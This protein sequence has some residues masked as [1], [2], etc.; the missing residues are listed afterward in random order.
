MV[1]TLAPRAGAQR[2]VVFV[3]LAVAFGF[4]LWR[5]VTTTKSRTPAPRASTSADRLGR[6]ALPTAFGQE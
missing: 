3:A 4:A 2:A 5:Y 6:Q 1:G